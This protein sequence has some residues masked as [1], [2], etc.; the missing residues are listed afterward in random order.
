LRDDRKIVHS[1]VESLYSLQI[2]VV[3]VVKTCS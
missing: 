3:T 1:G 2:R